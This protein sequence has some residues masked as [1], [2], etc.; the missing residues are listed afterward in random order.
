M[1]SAIWALTILQRMLKAIS[2][3]AVVHHLAGF[4]SLPLVMDVWSGWVVA[5]LPSL[6]VLGLRLGYRLALILLIR[7][8]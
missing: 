3:M 2:V 7:A 1:F 8:E 5:V 6:F 4:E